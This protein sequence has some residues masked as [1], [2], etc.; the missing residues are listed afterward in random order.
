MTEFYNQK[1][2]NFDELIDPAP[3]NPHGPL[4][5]QMPLLP[6]AAA[7]GG[8]EPG[9]HGDAAAGAPELRRQHG[10][11]GTTAYSSASSSASSRATVV[12]CARRVAP[13]PPSR[14]AGRLRARDAGHGS[15]SFIPI[16]LPEHKKQKFANRGVEPNSNKSYD[17][18]LQAAAMQRPAAGSKLRFSVAHATGED[19]DYPAAGAALPHAADQGVAVRALQQV[20][21]GAGAAAGPPRAHPPDPVAE[22]RVQDSHQDRA[23]HGAAAAGGD[24][25][26]PH[27]DA[28]AGAL[29]F[30]ANTASGHQARELKSVHVN[31][32]AVILRVVVHKC[33]VNKLNIYNQV[34]IV[35]LNVIGEPMASGGGL[36][37]GGGGMGNP[38]SGPLRPRPAGVSDLALDLDMDPVTAVKIREIHQLKEEAVAQEDY[39]EAARL[40]DGMNRLKA[41]GAKVAQLEARKRA[42]VEA[43]DYD[44]AKV[45]KSEIDKLR[46]AGRVVVAAREA[47]REGAVREEE[48][49]EAG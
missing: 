3:L 33:H 30:D 22:P 32:D 23:V 29:S 37:G 43:E 8:D 19:P 7:A 45:I 5:P 15:G 6:G 25:P 1:S 16:S 31:V 48:E 27:G 9:P 14:G 26:G 4:N 11:V 20:P 49:G 35:A 41:V 36:S 42:A 28:A 46:Q 13:S 2:G 40:R 21:P 34:G 12:S 24:E 17:V 47:E 39:D 10:Q 18:V 44:A 38:T